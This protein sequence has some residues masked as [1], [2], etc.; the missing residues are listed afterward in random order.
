MSG[1]MQ[2]PSSTAFIEEARKGLEKAGLVENSQKY[3]QTV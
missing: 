2:F 1:L 3:I